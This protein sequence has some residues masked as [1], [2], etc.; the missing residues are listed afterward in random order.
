[1][2]YLKGTINV[3]FWNTGDI[4]L[5]LVSLSNYGFVGFKLD[6]KCASDTCHILGSNLV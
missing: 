5:T 2:K 4:P 6:R 3:R 1:L